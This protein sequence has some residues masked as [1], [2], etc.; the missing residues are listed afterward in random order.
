MS[1]APSRVKRGLLIVGLCLS[2]P[3]LVAGLLAL[4]E[5]AGTAP[6]SYLPIVIGGT[7]TVIAVET[8]TLDDGGTMTMLDGLVIG[9][10]TNTITASLQ[11][12]VARIV[13]PSQPLFTGTTPLGGYYQISA[14]EAVFPPLDKPFVLGL[15]VPPGVPT[16]NLGVAVLLPSK[17]L[18]DADAG[19]RVWLPM[20][21]TFDTTYRLFLVTLSGLLD[22]GATFVLIDHPDLEPLIPAQPFVRQTDFTLAAN[23]PYRVDCF[24][25]AGVDDCLPQDE[26]YVSLELV[27]DD[28]DLIGTLHFRPPSLNLLLGGVVPIP[29][30][31]AIAVALAPYVAYHN[32]YIEPL[33]SCGIEGQAARGRY[34]PS[35]PSLHICKDPDTAISSGTD[36]LGTIRHELFHAIQF[37]YPYARTS[38]FDRWVVEGTA[39]VAEHSQNTMVRDLDWGL[40][41]VDPS[42]LLTLSGQTADSIN[43]DKRYL[44][45]QTQDFWAFQGLDAGKGLDY[46]QPLF[47]AGL[48]TADVID[49]LGDGDYMEAYWLWA[50]NQVME[51]SIDLDG[52]LQNPCNY[53]PG[54]VEVLPWFN[55]DW[56]DIKKREYIVHVEPLSTAVVKM[57]MD[58]AYDAGF[59][60]IALNDLGQDPD[61]TKALRYKI[62]VDGENNCAGIPEGP[63]LFPQSD[64]GMTTAEDYY[65]VI[66]NIDDDAGYDYKIRLE[67]TPIPPN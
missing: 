58:G 17:H 33:T 34:I 40:R 37:A 43:I 6:S 30:G 23:I 63:R 20:L 9:T 29:A 22:E 49:V 42:L 35:I 60:W 51:K 27:L 55:H 2:V 12:T 66:S 15:P 62:Y 52:A 28:A 59:V 44:E 56:R 64:G 53:V 16:S 14:G 45:Y 57:K 61:A 3:G 24:G 19:V 50:S 10:V 4:T 21:G 18:W 36:I 5:S 8:G 13:P 67:L 41:A 26:D 31:S 54:V 7:G 25:F 47:E 32:I 39:A 38:S 11:I 46:L 1:S 48:E 65:V